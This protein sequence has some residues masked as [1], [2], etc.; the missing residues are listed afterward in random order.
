MCVSVC[1][2]SINFRQTVKASDDLFFIRPK[3][4]VALLVV[5]IQVIGSAHEKFDV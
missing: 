1:V 2:C 4:N 5:L 3:L